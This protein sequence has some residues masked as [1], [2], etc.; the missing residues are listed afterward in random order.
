[1]ESF[2]RRGVEPA[3]APSETAPNAR[4]ATKETPTPSIAPTTAAFIGQ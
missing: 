3:S 2:L 4:W 1:M